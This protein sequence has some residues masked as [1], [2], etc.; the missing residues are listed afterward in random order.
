[1]GKSHGVVNWQK[2]ESEEWR[3][4]G[5]LMTLI[6]LSVNQRQ[7]DDKWKR[8]KGVEIKDVIVHLLVLRWRRLEHV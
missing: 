8:K 1:M 5:Q 7:E 6:S 3:L 4:L 2:V